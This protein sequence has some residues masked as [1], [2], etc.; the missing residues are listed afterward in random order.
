MD[1]ALVKALQINY[2]VN[3]A[4]RLSVRRQQDEFYPHTALP[5]RCNLDLTDMGTALPEELEEGAQL[6]G[7]GTS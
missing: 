6:P 3:E 7:S 4:P 2:L 1:L 5:A